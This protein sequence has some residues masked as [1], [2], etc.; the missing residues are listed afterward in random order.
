MHVYCCSRWG[1]CVLFITILD[2]LTAPCMVYNTAMYTVYGRF[3]Q[4]GRCMVHTLADAASSSVIAGHGLPPVTAGIGV[5]LDGVGQA[6]MYGT[7]E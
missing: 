3:G 5:W 6:G 7:A 4:Y 2:S 1:W